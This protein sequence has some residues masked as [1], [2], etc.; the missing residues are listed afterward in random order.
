MDDDETTMKKREIGF[1][2]LFLSKYPEGGRLDAK[3]ISVSDMA[4]RAGDG[5]ATAEILHEVWKG[6][7]NDAGTGMGS[8]AGS[9]RPRYAA[10]H[11]TI[12]SWRRGWSSPRPGW[13]DR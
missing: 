10:S 7:C 3:M 5:K 13:G 8:S 1:W 11:I 9:T 6:Q 2:R 12:W 4:Q